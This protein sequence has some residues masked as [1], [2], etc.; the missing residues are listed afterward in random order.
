MTGMF[1]MAHSMCAVTPFFITAVSV[2]P[3]YRLYH[4]THS[5][6]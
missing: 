4:R 1:A 6:V 3:E 5:F 2:A